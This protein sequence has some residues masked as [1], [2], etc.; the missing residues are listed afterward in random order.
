MKM[1]LGNDFLGL[2][3]LVASLVCLGTWPALLRL[4][5][6]PTNNENHVINQRLAFFQRRNTGPRDTRFVYIDYSLAYFMVSSVPY[7]IWRLTDNADDVERAVDSSKNQLPSLSA[8]LVGLA[9]FGGS[10][11]SFGNLSMQWATAVYGSALTTVLAIQASMTVVLGTSVNFAIEPDKTKRPHLLFAGIIFFLLAIVFASKAHLVYGKEKVERWQEYVEIELQGP[12]NN[13]AVRPQSYDSVD[14]NPGDDLLVQEGIDRDS[15]EETSRWKEETR[16]PHWTALTVAIFGGLCFGFFSP[17]FNFAVNDPYDITNGAPLLVVAANFW[18][19]FAF[20]LASILGNIGLL[21]FPPASSGMVSVP[22]SMYLRESLSDRNIAFAAG[23]VC[24]LGNILQFQGGSMVGFATSDL[25]QAFPLVSTLW[26][27]VL[28]EEFS[29]P[30]STV[31][32]TLI[33]MYIN[34]I[35]AIALL[36]LSISE[37]R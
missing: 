21:W 32:V 27:V 12:N 18:F 10:L 22:L 17:A 36:A 9:I 11:L 31:C 14:N 24:S 2:L 25:V 8:P 1:S 6:L 35:V 30:S 20:A 33:A 4:C 16:S 29:R 37:R 26:D 34:Y 28:F 5:S 13:E 19:G 7:L 23:I 15:D 3:L